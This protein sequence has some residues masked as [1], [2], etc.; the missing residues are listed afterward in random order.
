MIDL[1][2]QKLQSCIAQDLWNSDDS[3]NSNLL[4]T[5][6][7]DI[8]VEWSGDGFF[9]VQKNKVT[10]NDCVIG[11]T[12]CLRKNGTAVEWTKY[13]K[14][15]LESVESKLF[16]IDA[17]ITR[18]EIEING[19]VWDYTRWIRPG[20]GIGKTL[21]QTNIESLPE[22]M[23]NIIDIY[24]NALASLIKIAREHNENTIPA[25]SLRHLM[26]DNAGYYFVKNFDLWDQTIQRVVSLNIELG[27]VFIK[28]GSSVLPS[29]FL[30]EWTTKARN[31]WNTLI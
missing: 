30:E 26:Q 6:N 2:T 18:S 10:F 24:Y 13:Q 3:N 8:M 20:S 27:E 17:P 5:P 22:H 31:K 25:L 12:Y 15:Y 29:G 14:W 11:H 9:E 7:K 28:A 19:E 1:L 21:A 23:I 16:R 4:I